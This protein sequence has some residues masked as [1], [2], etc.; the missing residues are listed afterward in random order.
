MRIDY[1]EPKKSCSSAQA[2]QS[3]PRKESTNGVFIC[4]LISGIICLVIG[5]ASGWMLSQRSAKKGFKAAME[6]QSLE[7]TPQQPKVQPA[8]Q[9]AA[10]PSAPATGTA[11]QQQQAGSSGP[12]PTAT[13]AAQTATDPPLSFY[14]T[15][16]SGQKSNVLGSGINSKDDK[17]AKQPLQAAMPTNITRPAPAPPEDNVQKQPVQAAPTKAATRQDTNGFTVQVA[18][19]SLKSEAEAQRNK[20][21]TKGYNVSIVESH[22]PDK[23]TW[24]R[25]RVGKRLEPDAAKELA[26][27]L[28]KGSIAIPDKD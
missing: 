16:P 25:V 21:A 13:G 24:Y 15:L 7:N 2:S 11:T 10:A 26:G 8:P 5:F 18:S 12:Q 17:P 19:F 20:L 14:K 28:G 9:Q 3:R 6:Q 1:S 27:K 23:G 22:V 4:A